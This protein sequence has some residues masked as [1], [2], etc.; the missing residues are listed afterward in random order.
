MHT[1]TPSLVETMHVD[2]AGQIPLL[3]YH[4]ARLQASCLAL[5]YVW[6]DAGTRQDLDATAAKTTE[7]G[8]HRLRLLYFPEG[9]RTLQLAPLPAL[10][11][12]LSICLWPERL[13]SDEPWLRHKTTY[14]PWYATMTQWLSTQPTIFDA[15]C[16]NERGELCE[17]SRSNVYLFL[18]EQWFTPPTSSGCLA[19]VQRAMLLDQGLVHERLLYEED[20]LHASHLRISNALRGWR[21]V[22]LTS[23]NTPHPH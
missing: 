20:V 9:R 13:S 3:A 14:R 21:E 5:N 2:G 19:G 18:E 7:S 17:G 10:P 16:C 8:S 12:R 15:L 22:A 4:L 6:D 11:T 1:L 23:A